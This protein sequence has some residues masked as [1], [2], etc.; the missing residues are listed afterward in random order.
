AI[1]TLARVVTD[2][3]PDD[4][5][6]YER[7]RALCDRAGDQRGLARVLEH[8]LKHA[9]DAPARGAAAR[10]LA[11]LYEGKQPDEARALRALGEWATAL[12]DD[13]APRR[14]LATVFERKRRFKDLLGVLDELS[15]VEESLP[16]RL[17]A[18]RRAAELALG[19]LKDDAGAWQRIA[20]LVQSTDG[21]LDPGITELARRAGRL[22]ELADLCEAEGRHDELLGLLRER[23]A[24]ESDANTKRELQRRLANVLIEHRQDEAGAL[25][26]YEALLQGG[27]DAE[28]L[29]FVQAWSQRHDD[30]ARLEVALQRLANLEKHPA[31]KRDLLFERGRILGTRLS[32]AAEAIG[33]LEE[34]LALDGRFEAALDELIAACTSAGNHA[35]LVTALERKLGMASTTEDKLDVLR[36]LVDLYDGPLADE[37][38][39]LHALDRWVAL[40]RSDAEPLRRIRVLHTRAGRFHELVTTLDLLVE[41]EAD[42]DARLEARI[43]AAEITRDKLR[44]PANA[45]QRLAPLVPLASPEADAVLRTIAHDTQRHD[46]LH[47]L[48]EQ[49]ERFDDLTDELERDAA[50]QSDRTKRLRWLLRAAHVADKQL[51]DEDR[52]AAS[53]EHVLELEENAVALQFKGARARQDDDA[54]TLASVLHRL[55]AIEGDP[56]AKRD[57]LYEHA[58]VLN[59][60]LQKPRE[61]IAVLRE[62]VRLDPA[63]EPALD[64][65]ASAAEAAGDHEAHAEALTQLM[66]AE[67]EPA[68]KAEMA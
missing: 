44:D 21:A 19:K 42:D 18:L 59:L 23:I 51:Q 39:A 27:D 34:A 17:A 22:A 47:D 7:L 66:A 11:D 2:V 9:E 35:K 60:R 28:A 62:I 14:R 48:L 3:A 13:Y 29:R 53:Y 54:A 32:R 1:D 41:H 36:R 38:R 43:A 58:H 49:A 52:A 56:Q 4:W 26:V 61:A 65:L 50:A 45:F 57:L 63:F 25:E 6:S 20:L 55:A 8:R 67:Q 10:E 30:P 24:T 46:E 64:E 12:P 33:V 5:A 31:D 16:E 37:R 40:D 68:R 15:L